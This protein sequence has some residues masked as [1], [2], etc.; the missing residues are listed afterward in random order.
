M[1]KLA[2][3]VESISPFH[4]MAILDKAKMLQASGEDVI[5]L[6]VGEPDFVTDSS[7]ANA[8]IEAIQKHHTGYTSATGLPELKKTLSAYY[9][10]QYQVDV[11][12]ERIIVTSGA[13]GALLLLSS[14][15]VNSDDNVLMPDPCYPCNRHFLIQV[16][17]QAKLVET[18]S[19]Q[20]FAIDLEQL[21]EY[22]DD[23]TSGLWLASPSNPTGAVLDQAYL[24][25]AFSKV[26]RLGGHLMVDEI[27][28]GLVYEGEDMTALS[29]SD[30]IFVINS[31][32]KKFAMTGW[33]L[34]WA[35]VPEWAIEGATKLAQN[36]FISAPTV[37][38]YAA[39]R[40]L[41][42]DVLVGCE[43]RRQVLDKRRQFLLKELDRLGLPVVAPA[44]GAFYVFVDV[45]G[46]T[47][48]AMQWCLGLLDEYK[49]ALT[50]GDDFGFHN[51]HKYVRFAY[52][53][54]EARLEEA[55]KRI[56]QYMKRKDA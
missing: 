8:G 7:V 17:A 9:K 35:V 42:D 14:L 51:S 19:S 52:T 33:R 37:S 16:G 39:V 29:I 55:L 10:K 34:G 20:Q 50:P 23:K 46:I 12:P 26:S 28:Q 21:S 4:V 36:L 25:T 15:L 5:H 30:D 24:E 40:A 48:N 6:E 1:S 44:Q 31:F 22:W 38:Q 41:E 11:S 43:S 27:Y 49:V 45:S 54:N 32:S 47:G 13:S 3:R 2:H 56:E 53:C 18:H